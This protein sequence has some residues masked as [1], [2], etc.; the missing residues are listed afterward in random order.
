MQWKAKNPVK[1]LE[2]SEKEKIIEEAQS[3]IILDMVE[4]QVDANVE[5]PEIPLLEEG[6]KDQTGKDNR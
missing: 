5:K 6:K 3:V 1:Q 4:Q 2:G